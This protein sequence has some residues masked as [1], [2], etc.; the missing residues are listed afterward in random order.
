MLEAIKNIHAQIRDDVVAACNRQSTEELSRV[1]SHVDDEGDTIFAIDR[2]SEDRLLQMVERD[3][4][5]IAPVVLI[6]EG[7]PGG[8]CVLPAGARAEDAAYRMI[9]DPIDGTRGLMYQKRSA[10]ILT[11]LAPNRGPQT[12]LRDIEVAVQTE[13][14]IVKQNQSDMLWAV[15]GQG[16]HAERTNLATGARSALALRPSRAEGLAH[17]FATIARF[18]PGGRDVLA[19]LDDELALRL[20]GG[21]LKPDDAYCFEDQYISTGGQLYELMVGHDR[22]VADLRPLLIEGQRARGWPAPFCCHPYDL[23]SV[24]IAEEAGVVITD[25]QSQPMNCPLDLATNVGWIGYANATLHERIEPVLQQLLR[26]HGLLAKT[27]A[28]ATST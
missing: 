6:A 17:G 8:S 18:F 5:P 23:A 12:S 16:A 9:V 22:F 10:W 2:V 15:R 27:S 19:A 20:A 11:G 14:P 25:T 13:I 3:I 4:A 21:T 1:S 24:L 28:M 7:L 26:Q